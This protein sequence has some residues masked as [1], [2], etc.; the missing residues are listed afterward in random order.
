MS[1]E[2]IE[3]INAAVKKLNYGHRSKFIRDAIVEKLNREGIETPSS[4][5][6]A[7][8]RFGKRRGGAERGI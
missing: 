5:A 7:P 8:V 3:H 1:E 4:L 2:F 6:A